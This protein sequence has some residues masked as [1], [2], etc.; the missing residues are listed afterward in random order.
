MSAYVYVLEMHIQP[1]AGSPDA[2]AEKLSV[3]TTEQSIILSKYI[4]LPLCLSAPTESIVITLRV[5]WSL[6]TV[7]WFFGLN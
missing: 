1:S 5:N 7:C 3:A 2:E 6:S 4:Q